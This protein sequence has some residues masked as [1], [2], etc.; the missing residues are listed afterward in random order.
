MK[1]S[2]CELRE[3]FLEPGMYFYLQAKLPDLSPE[4]LEA[5]IEEAL[6]FLYLSTEC[7]GNIPVTREIDDVWHLLILQTA[8]YATLC[9]RM[10]G[11]QFIHH[12]SRQFLAYFETADNPQGGLRN[13][14]RMLG[15]YVQNFG[16]FKPDRIRFWRLADYLVTRVGWS[17][18]ELNEWLAPCEPL[19]DD[20]RVTARST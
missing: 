13:E 8:E 19:I 2:G 12:C 1:P 11:G 3:S 15:L 18:A 14:V 5:R 20:S 6:K 9:R 10:P 7:S 16:Q 17:V 4:D